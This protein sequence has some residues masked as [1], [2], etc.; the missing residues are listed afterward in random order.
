MVRALVRPPEKVVPEPQCRTTV[1]AAVFRVKE[2][3]VIAAEGRP[4]RANMGGT[5]ERRSVP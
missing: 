5:A 1:S 4:S 2:Q 3:A